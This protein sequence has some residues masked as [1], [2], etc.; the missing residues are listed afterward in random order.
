MKELAE[1]KA[2]ISAISRNHGE[3][4]ENPAKTRE[5]K[6]KPVRSQTRGVR[7]ANGGEEGC[8]R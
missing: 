2:I 8:V 1:H 6:G 3:S 5:S 7:C 4:E